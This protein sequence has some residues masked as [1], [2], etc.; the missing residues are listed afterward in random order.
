[1]SA[2]ISRLVSVQNDTPGMLNSEDLIEIDEQLLDYLC[3]GRVTPNYARMRLVEDVKDYSRGYVQQR[4]KRLVEHGHVVNLL[5]SGLYEL[6]DDPRE[7]NDV[8]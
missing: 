1:M 2:H 5:D 4:L 3:E 6:V 7:G 8:E